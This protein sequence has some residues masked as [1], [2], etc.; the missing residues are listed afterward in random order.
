VFW[1]IS[2]HLAF[3]NWRNLSNTDI[4]LIPVQST[5]GS[6]VSGMSFV[7]L[8][9]IIFRIFVAYDQLKQKDENKKKERATK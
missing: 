6:L 7:I 5:L 2:W 8:Q 4:K 3:I 9:V 1:F